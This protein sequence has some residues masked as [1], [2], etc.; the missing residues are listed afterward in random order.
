[1]KTVDLLKMLYPPV[2]YD[3]NA[4]LLSAT[5][6]AD[7]AVLDD[8]LLAAFGLLNEVFPDTTTVGL[9]DWERVYGLPNK[10]L[11]RKKTSVAARRAF[12][13]AAVND[14]GGIR[15][16]DY[17]AL[18]KVV[19]GDDVT[20]TE[21]DQASCAD[22]CD[23]GLFTEDWRYVWQVNTLSWAAWHMT[24][25]DSCVDPLDYFDDDALMCVLKTN[26]PAGTLPFIEFGV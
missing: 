22:A 17:I 26:A 1:M 14:A 9:S 18:V 11:S 20:V 21:F 15:N 6:T 5:I 16:V 10:C 23:V 7:A 12:L 2:S 24:C 25:L 13:M 4:P 8:V 19:L 3:V